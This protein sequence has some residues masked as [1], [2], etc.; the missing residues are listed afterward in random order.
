MQ[1][2][3]YN[4]K[5]YVCIELVILPLKCVCAKQSWTMHA[6]WPT[7]S[8]AQAYEWHRNCVD[9]PH[10]LVGFF[11]PFSAYSWPTRKEIKMLIWQNFCFT[12]SFR[13]VGSDRGDSAAA[14]LPAISFMGKVSRGGS[15]ADVCGGGLICQSVLSHQAF[16]CSKTK[17]PESLRER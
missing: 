14:A 15:P 4:N 8:L 17:K 6:L 3:I 16:S 9:F 5:L 1:L 2:L 10:L 13:R 7:T 12:G 11:P